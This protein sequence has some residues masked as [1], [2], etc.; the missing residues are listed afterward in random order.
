MNEISRNVVVVVI[1]VSTMTTL[2][3]LLPVFRPSKVQLSV[4]M[5]T[6]HAIFTD[7]FMHSDVGSEFALPVHDAPVYAVADGVRVMVSPTAALLYAAIKS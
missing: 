6:A 5:L 1:P 7:V 2:L 4:A 3:P